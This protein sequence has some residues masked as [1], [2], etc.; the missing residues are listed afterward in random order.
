MGLISDVTAVEIDGGSPVPFD[1]SNPVIEI[2]DTTTPP[3]ISIQVEATSQIVEVQVAG[4]QG[5]PGLQNVYPQTNDPSVEFGW[6]PEEAGF[7]WLQV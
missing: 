6:G 3:S 1:V 7:V 4:P 5:P 2:Q